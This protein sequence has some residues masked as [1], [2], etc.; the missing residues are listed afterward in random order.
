MINLNQEKRAVRA[1]ILARVSSREQ[2]D[3]KSLN[4]Q[5]NNGKDYCA[6][7]GLVVEKVFSIV[8]SSTQ[9]TRKQ[10]HQ[11]LDYIKEQKECIAIVSDTVDR[12]QR[13]FKETL[14]LNPML[15]E[16]EVELHFISN[17]LALHKNSSASEK[18]MWSMCVLMAQN[19]VLQLSDNTKRG[20]NQKVKDGE[21][22]SKAPVGYKNVTINE[23]KTVVIDEV[24]APMVKMVFERYATGTYS[25]DKAAEDFKKAGIISCRNVPFVASNMHKM[26]SNPFYYGVMEV[27]GQLIPHVHEPL[28]TKELFDRCQEVRLGYRRG[29]LNYAA[30]EFAFKNMIV[31]G[32]CGRHFCGYSKMKKKKS[33]EIVEHRYLRCAGRANKKEIS[34]CDT[35][36]LR[37]K[38]AE[39]QILAKLEE[40][41]VP[42]KMLSFSLT[43]LNKGA[44]LAAEAQ[45]SQENIYRRRLGQI[46][47]E[48]EIWVSKEATGLISSDVVN[49][50]LKNLTEEEKD[51]Q[52]KLD[53]PA[54]NEKEVLW[55]LSRLTNLMSRLPELYKSSQPEQKRRIMKLIIANLTMKQKNLEIIM[56]KPFQLL[57]EG[58]NSS[59]WGG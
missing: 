1:V 57:L 45:K 10:F 51:L 42:A 2:E 27:K 8:E 30:R 58:P 55:T 39:E 3:G 34:H 23:K 36:Q 18:T 11:M 16:G 59:V 19:Y 9:G 35:P 15:N 7:K 44:I 6:R 22:P 5:Q 14:E 43:E 26:I 56:K 53:K 20:L 54:S 37:E 49:E 28:I 32:C 21:W 50:K 40:L 4:A 46:A 17:G 25:I 12:F 47:R 31:C 52:I 33:G 38:E 13:S 24:I 41:K 48:K 29:H